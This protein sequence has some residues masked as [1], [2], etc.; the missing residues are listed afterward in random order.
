MSKSQK[1]IYYILLVLVSVLFVYAGIPKLIGSHQESVGFAMMHL[2]V[3]VMY[4]VGV[5][6][7]AGAIGL[8]IPKLQKWAAIGLMIIMIGAIILTLLFAGTVAVIFPFVT[9][10]LV[11]AVA[12]LG[13]K[14][15]KHAA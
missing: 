6:E 3:W 11:T 1:I 7:I 9:L 15:R 4:V 2:P 13:A 10:L 5:A 14:M 8:W 12:M